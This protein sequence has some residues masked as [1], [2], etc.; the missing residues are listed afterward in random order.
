MFRFATLLAFGLLV[1]GCLERELLRAPIEALWKLE[2][3]SLANRRRRFVSFLD[4]G[5]T[6]PKDE[7]LEAHQCW[8]ITAGGC[9][10][11][12]RRLG[13]VLFDQKIQW[14]ASY[15]DKEPVNFME[16]L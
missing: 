11:A 12:S 8:Q 2:T 4:I 15:R 1:K 16:W 14:V 5:A 10:G 6:A 13:R 7:F 3:Y 9:P